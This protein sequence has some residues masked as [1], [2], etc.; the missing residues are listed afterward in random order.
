MAYHGY[1]EVDHT[2]DIALR[3]WGENY[4]ALLQQSAAGMYDLMGVVPIPDSSVDDFI[5]VPAGTYE[6]VMVDFLSELLFLA[7]ENSQVLE[8]FSFS[9]DGIDLS[10]MCT[11]RKIHTYERHIKAVTF[12]NLNVKTTET[13]LEVTITFDV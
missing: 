7:E 10:I 5:S 13:G 6:T 12:H 2:A 1:E 3:V 4:W 8:H 9:D 11:G